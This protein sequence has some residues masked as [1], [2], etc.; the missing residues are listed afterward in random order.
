VVGKFDHP[1]KVS[2]ATCHIGS[3]LNF[4]NKPYMPC[5]KLGGA[6]GKEF[7]KNQASISH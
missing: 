6:Y 7:Y 1:I 2:M 4:A 3:T 5:S